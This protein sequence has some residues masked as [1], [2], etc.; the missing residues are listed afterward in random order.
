MMSQTDK[1]VRE[2]YRKMQLIAGEIQKY[3][4]FLDSGVAAWAKLILPS[5]W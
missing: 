3:K 4:F 5:S 1:V 2:A